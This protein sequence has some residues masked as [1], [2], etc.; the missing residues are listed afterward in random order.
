VFDTLFDEF[1]GYCA[2]E[3]GLA[4]S[5]MEAYARD[6]RL[7]ASQMEARAAAGGA[8]TPSELRLA[9][10]AE[11]VQWLSREK[12]YEPTTIAQHLAAIRVF[13]RWAH[14]TGRLPNDPAR[15]VQRPTRWRRVPDALSPTQVRTLVESPSP[16]HGDLWLR[17]RAILELMYAG[18]LRASEVC[19]LKVNDYT[20]TLGCV[21]VIGK[22]NKQR[23]VPIGVPS[24]AWIDRWLHEPAGRPALTKGREGRDGFRMFLSHTGKPLERVALWHIVQRCAA[25]AGLGRIHPHKLRHTFATHLVIGGADLR[26]VQEMLGHANI[27]TTQVY[28]HVD[29]SRLHQVLAEFHPREQVARRSQRANQPANS[30]PSPKLLKPSEPP[31]SPKPPASSRRRAKA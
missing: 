6:L 28:T 10:I 17:D 30:P 25:R 1:F 19:T 21:S 18:G 4:P 24:M 2:V 12:E 15:L 3:V 23:L 11:H 16:D 5:S 8:P 27:T 20:K 7:F 13:F 31:K 22:G 26:V 29:R 14:A 9:D